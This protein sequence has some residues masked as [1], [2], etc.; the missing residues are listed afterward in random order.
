[1]I[2]AILAVACVILVEK[3]ALSVC[4]LSTLISSVVSLVENEAESVCKLSTL[5][6]SVVNRVE[7]LELSDVILSENLN[8]PQ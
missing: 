7:I 5:I 2:P 4:K 6:S 1:M 3:L 8:Y